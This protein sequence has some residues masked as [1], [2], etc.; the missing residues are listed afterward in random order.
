MAYMMLSFC[1][2]LMRSLVAGTQSSKAHQRR[3]EPLSLQLA[4]EL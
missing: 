2:R 4:P 1:R 3:L